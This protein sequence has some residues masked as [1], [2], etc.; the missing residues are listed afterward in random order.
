MAVTE[1]RTYEFGIVFGDGNDG[2]LDHGYTVT[3]VRLD[4]TE[5]TVSWGGYSFDGGTCIGGETLNEDGGTED[6]DGNEIEGETWV[7]IDV[8]NYIE[9]H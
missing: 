1:R 6:E 5:E 9:V 2:N 8:V 3:I 7:P 4:G